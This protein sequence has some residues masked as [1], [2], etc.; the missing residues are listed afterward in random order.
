MSGSGQL[1]HADHPRRLVPE[2]SVNAAKAGW[3]VGIG[4]GGFF[5]I[6][7]GDSV[8]VAAS[9][10]VKS[11]VSADDLFI[12][13]VNDSS[14]AL[15]PPAERKLEPCEIIGLIMLIF[16]ERKGCG[17]VLHSNGQDPLLASLVYTGPEFKIRNQGAIRGVYN[18]VLRR[19]YSPDEE[20]CVPIV[21]GPSLTEG[22]LRNAIRQNPHAN[23]VIIRNQGMFVWAENWQKCQ[24]M[25]E[26]YHLLMGVAVQ[27]EKLGL[28]AYTHDVTLNSVA[29]ATPMASSSMVA[30]PKPTPVST[31][32][33]KTTPA[34][35]VK[36]SPSPVS[37]P[38]PSSAPVAKPPTPKP[39]PSP[40]APKPTPSPAA[41]SASVKKTTPNGVKTSP[42][43]K[44]SGQR[45]GKVMKRGQRGAGRGN[46]RA[47]PG[48]QGHGGPMGPPM[49]GPGGPMGPPMGGPP[50]GPPM[51]GPPMGPPMMGPDPFAMG[52]GPGGPPMQGGPARGGRGGGRRGGRGGP[53]GRGGPG[54]KRSGG[55]GPGRQ[56]KKPHGMTKN[57]L[58]NY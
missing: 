3:F 24:A 22:A 54:G 32:A 16:K 5:S 25:A 48:P 13:K 28:N 8:Y 31:P 30:P 14:V 37:K 56:N 21:D 19:N 39:T 27:M 45:G 38:T 2:L 26:C 41:A 17:A 18:E 10:V 23:A 57:T 29:H 35:A 55:G 36:A 6:K 42:L 9:N 4:A 43:K 52:M 44:T 51:M 12:Y 47:S 49:G 50:M 53:S 33:P 7:Q 1:F 34:A 11:R 40:A 20:L 46:V 58:M 15:S